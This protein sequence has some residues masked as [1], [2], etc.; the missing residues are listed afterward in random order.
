MSQ[1]NGSNPLHSARSLSAVEAHMRAIRERTQDLA[2]AIGVLI[3]VL[4]TEKQDTDQQKN[5]EESKRHQTP[6]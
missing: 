3:N 2:Q 1:E 5:L 6:F 4:P